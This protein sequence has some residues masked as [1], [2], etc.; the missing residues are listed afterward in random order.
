MQEVCSV[1]DIDEGEIEGFEVAG[2]EI[3]VARVDGEFY[4]IGNVCTHQQCHLSDGWLED[5]SVVCPCHSAKFDLETGEVE[6]PPADD[7]EPVYETEIE[8]DKVLVG[9]SQT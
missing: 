3:L 1:D 9:L 2:E 4:A 7:P 8:N 6:R 5:R